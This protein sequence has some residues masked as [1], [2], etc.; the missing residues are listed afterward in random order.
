MSIRFNDFP[1]NLKYHA[2]QYLDPISAALFVRTSVSAKKEI[3]ALK[4]MGNFSF[5]INVG[6]HITIG[7]KHNLSQNCVV[8]TGKCLMGGK[9]VNRSVCVPVTMTVHQATNAFFEFNVLGRRLLSLNEPSGRG[10]L[11]FRIKLNEVI[12]SAKNHNSEERLIDKGCMGG[13]IYFRPYAE[14]Q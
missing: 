5:A 6:K 12:I 13:F 7:K 11:P 2:L 3:T 14:I 10:P 9:K 8:I 1:K 4:S